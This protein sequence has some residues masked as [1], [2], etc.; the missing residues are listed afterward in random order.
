MPGP[1]ATEVAQALRDPESPLPITQVKPFEVKPA[2]DAAPYR[3]VPEP[4]SEGTEGGKPL[5]TEDRNLPKLYSAAWW[6]EKGGVTGILC[7]LVVGL[8]GWVSSSQ[9]ESQ[10]ALVNVLQ[11]S[12]D[13]RSKEAEIRNNDNREMNKAILQT[14]VEITDQMRNISKFMEKL[15]AKIDK[16]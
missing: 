15:E 16:K 4:G 11:R 6:F 7:F 9:G 5:Q 1:I 13:S 3:T 8:V 14:Q 2:A 10:K 12:E